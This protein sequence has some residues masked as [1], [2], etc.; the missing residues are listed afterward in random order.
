MTKA[1]KI[2]NVI[3][4]GGFP[5]PVQS[6]TTTKTEDVEATVA[7][8]LELENTLRASA[9]PGDIILTVGAGDVYKIGERLLE[10]K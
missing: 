3:I 10:S 9:A 1:V 6:M 7:Q 4:G 5:I 8:I 2:G